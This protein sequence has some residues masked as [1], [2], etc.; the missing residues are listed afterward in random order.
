[1][2]REALIPLSEDERTRLSTALDAID[3]EYGILT[4]PA[5]AY[6]SG[7]RCSQLLGVYVDI[8]GHIWP[9]VARTRL[10]EGQQ[11]NI[12]LGSIREGVLPSEV[13]SRSLTM[14]RIRRIYDGT[15]PLQAAVLRVDSQR[16]GDAT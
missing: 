3:R 4:E 13:W 8:H 10:D 2:A 7:S 5:K 6:Y 14:D 11:T 16:S 15:C 9:C 1:M 12:P